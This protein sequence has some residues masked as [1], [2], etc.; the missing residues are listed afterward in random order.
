MPLNNE[1]YQELVRLYGE[2]KIVN[3][4]QPYRFRPS[5]N[6]DGHVRFEDLEYGEQYYIKCP[7]CKDHKPR[8]TINHVCGTVLNG[9][10]DVGPIT[11]KLRCYN[12]DF[13]VKEGRDSL[14]MILRGYAHRCL[15]GISCLVATGP[16]TVKVMEQPGILGPLL[17]GTAAYKYLK[18]R[19]F[20]PEALTKYYN[21]QR[22]D[23]PLVDRAFLKERVYI[24]V[25]DCGKLVYWQARDVYDIPNTMPY[26]ISKHGVKSLFSFDLAK[27]QKYVVLSEGV[28]DAITIG[29]N[30]A[31]LFGKSITPKQIQQLSTLKTPIVIGLDPDAALEAHK[32]EEFLKTRINVPIVRVMYPP[33]WPK[34]FNKR[35]NKEMLADAAE[36]GHTKINELIHHTLKSNL[37]DRSNGLIS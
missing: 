4:G 28:F 3:E 33:T 24:P 34:I 15:R 26:Y 14:K 6:S 13:G 16:P 20:S 23:Q 1:L 36:V 11:W 10:K 17:P 19:N 22:I 29:I 32:M 9:F 27:Q 5:V 25:Y 12:C 18:D 21:I 8:L 35:K 7:I 31:A 37:G 30:G 2:V